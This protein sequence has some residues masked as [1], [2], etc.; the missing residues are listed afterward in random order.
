MGIFDV[1]AVLSLCQILV[2]MGI[3]LLVASTGLVAAGLIA[4]WF[5]GK[6]GVAVQSVALRTTLAALI[7]YP[8]VS[9]LLGFSGIRVV[10][11]DMPPAKSAPAELA[12]PG[13]SYDT[14][15]P[16]PREDVDDAS[17]STKAVPATEL[18]VAERAIVTAPAS[19]PNRENHADLLSSGE[20]RGIPAFL[21]PSLAVLWLL[22]AALLLTRLS[23][24]HWRMVKLRIR[25]KPAPAHLV[26]ACRALA[27]DMGIKPPAL[28][29]SAHVQT[30]CLVG[31]FSPAI[32]LPK[33]DVAHHS[34]STHDVIRHELAHLSRRDC[35]WNLFSRMTTAVFFFQ[36]FVWILAR[37][38]ERISEEAVDDFVVYHGAKP[39]DYAR[40]L[41]E[42]AERCRQIPSVLIASTGV[43]QF[44]SFLG[45][46]VQRILDTGRSL[47]VRVGFRAAA[48][49]IV[50][51]IVGTVALGLIGPADAVVP[52]CPTDLG[53][54]RSEVGDG[55]LVHHADGRIYLTELSSGETVHVGNGNQPEFSPNGTK[56]AWIDGRTAKGRMR[57]GDTSIHVIAENIRASGG[58]HWLTNT[59]LA[60]VIGKKW[61]RVELGGG[62]R[63]IPELTALGLGGYECD[64]K[65]GG[66]D[67]WSYVAKETWKTSDGKQGRV[68]GSCSV[69]LSPDGRSVTSLHGDH[70]TASVQAIR[71]GGTERTLRWAYG[72]GF[73]NHRWASNNARYIVV[74]DEIDQKRRGVTYPVVMRADG[75]RSTRM[76]NKGFAEHMVYGDFVV[77]DGVGKDWSGNGYATQAGT[78][79][80]ANRSV[81]TTPKREVK[82]A[83]DAKTPHDI[84]QAGLGRASIKISG[85]REGERAVI[86]V[87]A[88]DQRQRR[89]DEKTIA[90]LKKRALFTKEISSDASIAVPELPEGTYTIYAGAFSGQSRSVRDALRSLRYTFGLFEISRNRSADVAVQLPGFG[91]AAL[92]VT[93]MR[94]GDRTMVHLLAGD[95]RRNLAEALEIE[96]VNEKAVLESRHLL[97]GIIGRFALFE[98]EIRSDTSIAV[99][100]LPEGT[101]TIYAGALNGR[102]RSVR[103]A[104]RSLRYT[105]G[106]VEIS[107][108]K[109]TDVPV[110]L[111]NAKVFLPG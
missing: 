93:G 17:A 77:G 57:K 7:L 88:G 33:A 45:K 28:L 68:A 38:L 5:L 1:G 100:E 89:V 44:N 97:V 49:I 22:V 95:Q 18:A 14:A 25:A 64:V 84:Q 71:P 37:Q 78:Q 34:S 58:I 92:W 9:L 11:L 3:I 90:E 74:V 80:P 102:S 27:H 75:S 52:A 46:R 70:M 79:T 51:G 53:W 85:M 109:T 98:K 32:L 60:L 73:D 36:P 31:L 42:V 35:L 29:A 26:N 2:R 59:E 24:A 107:R 39:S 91:R 13:E 8:V 20:P 110:Q 86:R 96:K 56:L 105:Y 30:P 66:D 54:L 99:P 41:V 15:R 103:D 47:S 101:Y 62:M 19:K 6:K 104:L 106:L 40:M 63:E 50:T 48:A 94:Q 23:A 61:F 55:A 81:R 16:A 82:T 69:S 43:S 4:A 12:S 108:N 83:L 87:L 10:S 65:L 72:G 21:Y 111:K 76:G 67:I